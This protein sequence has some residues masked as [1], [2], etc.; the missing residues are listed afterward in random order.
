[1]KVLHIIPSVALVRGGP[2]QAVL[3]MVKALNEQGI[4]AEIATTNDN[5]ADLLNVPLGQCSQY[6]QVPIWFFPRFSP[7]NHTVREFAFSS[8]F[9][10]WLWQ[11][12]DRYDLIH[13]HSVFSYC[14]TV[15]MAIARYHQIPYIV[16]TLG[17]LCK[18]SLQ[19]SSYRKQVYLKLI[20]RSNLNHAQAIHFTSAQEQTEASE[21]NLN[22]PSFVLPHGFEIPQTI[23]DAHQRLRQYLHLPSDE[24]IVLFLARLHPKKGLDYL[25]AALAKRSHHRFSF[26]LA[27]DGSLEYEAELR[28]LIA[29][30]NLQDRTHFTGFVNGDLKHLLLQGSDLFALTSYSEN[31]GVS[32][33][34]ALAAGL[35][36]LVTPGVALA[37]LV[38]EQQLGYV[39]DLDVQQIA[40]AIEQA[41]AN[42]ARSQQMGIRARQFTLDNYTWSKVATDMVEVYQSLVSEASRAKERHSIVDSIT[43]LV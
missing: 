37:D 8:E 19:Q 36:A 2:S 3:E 11:N 14:S 33:L 22:V 5:G 41:L 4:E 31:F 29:A 39:A 25:I 10:I 20:E 17:Q 27:G 15:A 43:E 9:T 40:G 38:R 7:T 26:V 12:I 34:E 30:H 28:S 35:P 18:W 13:I 32:V 23:P 6:E 1:M 21:L 24:P 42:P 16:R